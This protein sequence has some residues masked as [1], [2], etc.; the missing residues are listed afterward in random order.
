M[1]RLAEKAI[2]H[3]GERPSKRTLDDNVCR[4]NEM[5]DRAGKVEKLG[6]PTSGEGGDV[7]TAIT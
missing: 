2:H 3:G 6:G 1:F 4:R 5:G 7:M